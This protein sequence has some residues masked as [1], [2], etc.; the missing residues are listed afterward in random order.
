MASTVYSR[1]MGAVIASAWSACASNGGTVGDHGGAGQIPS[2]F[3]VTYLGAW[4]TWA[5]VPWLHMGEPEIPS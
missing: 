5:T 3:S 1:R 2:N 4:R